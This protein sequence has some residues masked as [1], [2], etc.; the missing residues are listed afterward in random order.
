M[1]AERL[2]IDQARRIHLLDAIRGF[3]LFGILLVN[4]QLFNSPKFFLVGTDIELWS[5][6]HNQLAETFIH[7]FATG[8]FYTMFSLLFGIGFYIFMER[9]EEK[10]L[11]VAAMF[12]RRMVG[13]LIFGGIHLVFIWIGDI[14]FTYAL[15]GFLLLLFRNKT[16]AQLR[17]W[18]FALYGGA[19]AVTALLMVAA[20]GISL[21]FPEKSGVVEDLFRE[22]VLVFSTGTYLDILSFRIS[23]ELPVVL[24]NLFLYVPTVLGIFLLGFYAAKTGLV[25]NPA[26]HQARL[27]SLWSGSLIIGI[28][29]IGVEGLLSGQQVLVH[30]LFDAGL[31]ELSTAVSGLSLSIFYMTSM[32]FIITFRSRA[33]AWLEPVGQMALTNY[34]MQ[35]LICITLFYGYGFG[36]YNQVGPLMGIVLT[37]S[38]F[39]IQIGLSYHWMKWFYYGPLEWLWRY[40]TYRERPRF[41]RDSDD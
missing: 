14:L 8:K 11:P 12:Q 34:I 36:F 23:E 3:A 31:G 26:E 19:A 18:G 1:D 41:K 4:M 38:I 39:C 9:V 21:Y 7:L 15:A 27:K 16:P 10:G 30:P 6:W 22:A 37:I 13:L 17:N 28:G 5:M 29:F 33:F 35:S 25:K 20:E 2:P 40:F 24:A 32:Y